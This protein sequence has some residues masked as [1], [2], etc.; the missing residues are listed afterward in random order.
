[1]ALGLKP[2]VKVTLGETWGRFSH[3]L[4]GTWGGGAH[5]LLKEGSNTW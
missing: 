1:M 5:P 3:H 2:S 4:N